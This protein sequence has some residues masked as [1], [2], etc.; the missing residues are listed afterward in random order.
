MTDFVADVRHRCRNPRCRSKLP[1]PVENPRNAFCVRGCFT[2]FYRHR[3]LVCEQEFARRR[4][5]QHICNRRKCKSAFRRNREQFFAKWYQDPS[6][7]KL[8]VKNPTKPGTFWCDKQ[9]RGWCWERL[10]GDDQLPFD[11]GGQPARA[12]RREGLR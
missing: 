11:P 10:P 6:S 12:T 5:D 7:V 3:C 8:G 1:A 2:S 4:D 9:G